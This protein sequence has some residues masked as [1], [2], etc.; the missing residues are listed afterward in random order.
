[1]KSKILLIGALLFMVIGPVFPQSG[2]PH[3][4]EVVFTAP[5]SVGGS[6]T[7]AG[8]NIYRCAGTCTA[9]SSWTLVTAA[10]DLSTGYLDASSD[11]ALTPGSTYSYAATAVDSTG[12]ESAFS[13]IAAVTI[14]AAGFPSNPNAPGGCNAKVQ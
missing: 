12:H 11:A 9:A 4:V 13:N 6:G 2:S 14:P 5:P 3:G 1:M 8:Y 10:L 7:L